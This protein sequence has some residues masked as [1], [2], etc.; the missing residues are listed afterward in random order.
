MQISVSG[1]DVD[2]WRETAG[3][4]NRLTGR[5]KARINE[6]SHGAIM[7][8]VHP[9]VRGALFALTMGLSAAPTFAEVYKCPDAA[10]KITYQQSPCGVVSAKGTIKTEGP[11]QTLAQMPA[12]RR[13]VD[14]CINLHEFSPN[15]PT[16]FQRY[17]AVYAPGGDGSWQL[18]VSGT[19]LKSGVRAE[20]M[21]RCPVAGNGEINL[22]LWRA[23]SALGSIERDRRTEQAAA[24][25]PA[26]TAAAGAPAKDAPRISSAEKAAERK[27][28]ESKIRGG[29]LNEDQIRQALGDPDMYGSTTGTCLLPVSRTAYAC[30]LPM[31]IYLPAERDQ[32]TRTT[33]T[34]S[35]DGEAIDVARAIQY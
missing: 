18:T 22:D 5:R 12:D 31:W 32:Q 14:Q 25:R 2:P 8:E 30:K 17:D 19:A 1:R 26:A 33:I 6:Y 23:Q 7:R 16:D 10:G 21:L 20:V 11:A 3:A 35:Q 4:H 24:A 9:V 15:R 28:I 34:F 27:F 13:I 29:R